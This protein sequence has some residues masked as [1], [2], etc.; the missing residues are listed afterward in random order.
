MPNPAYEPNFGSVPRAYQPIPARRVE[1]ADI[2]TQSSAFGAKFHCPVSPFARWD[3]K[4]GLQRD[5]ISSR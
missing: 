2:V 1:G 3:E 4:A 5:A